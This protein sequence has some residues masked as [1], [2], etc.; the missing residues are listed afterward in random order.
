MGM[1]RAIIFDLGRTVVDFEGG[2]VRRA[3]AGHC[4]HSPEEIG[5]LIAPT[6]LIP[7]F[8]SGEIAPYDFFREYAR[9][10]GLRLDYETFRGI[11]ADI[12]REVLIPEEILEGLAARYRLLLLSNTNEIHFEL[13]RGNYPILRHFHAMVLS[14]E[15][16]ALKPQPAIYQAAIDRAGC[17]PGECFFT[18]DIPAFVE[19]ARAMGI[20]AET[21]EGVEK[22]KR[23]L[24]TRNIR[25]L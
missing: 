25:W 3:L 6:G 12:F 14:H 11:W 10:L 1:H 8:E 17:P 20:D 24:E 2:S 9:V 5:K 15:V 22:L 19:G 13:L 16:H 23:D 18:D 21:F 4:D 7:R